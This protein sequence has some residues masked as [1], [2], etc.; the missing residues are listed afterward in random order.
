M[1]PLQEEKRKQPMHS[2]HRARMRARVEKYGLDSL[3]EHEALE[4]IL[5]FVIPRQ[6]TNPIAHA[7]IDRFGNF[8]NVLEAPEKELEAVPG[9]GPAAARFLHSLR[10]IERYDML[11]RRGPHTRLADTK[12][13]ADYLMPLFHGEKK[14]K[15]AMLALDD[16]R[17]LLRLIW[18]EDGSAGA[19][20]ISVRKIASAAVEAG[21]ACV[22]MAHNHPDGIVLPSREDLLSTQAVMQALS[23]LDIRLL[24]HLIFA[25]E[26]WISLRDAGRMSVCG[27]NGRIGYR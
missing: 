2:D 27:P 21:A 17:R 15:L 11:S 12:Q 18:L 13:L 5:F 16:R 25:Q 19:V 10:E 9:I 6:D 8:A 20:D 1:A 26:E 4:Y 3:A 23:L 22:V 14:E 24:D 7:L